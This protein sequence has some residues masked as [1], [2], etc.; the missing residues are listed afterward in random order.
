MENTNL[1]EKLNKD[2]K[3][4]FEVGLQEYNGKKLINS[5]VFETFNFE[6]S[7]IVKKDNGSYIAILECGCGEMIEEYDS[8]NNHKYYIL[9]NSNQYCIKSEQCAYSGGGTLMIT[10][11]LDD[12]NIMI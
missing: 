8:H 1:I 7:G 11:K 9:T 3:K 4:G 12:L 2:L 10:F 6:E 5:F